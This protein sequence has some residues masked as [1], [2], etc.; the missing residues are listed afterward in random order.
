MNL[1]ILTKNQMWKQKLVHHFLSFLPSRE[2]IENDM[3]KELSRRLKGGSHKETLTN[4]LEWQERNIH[5]WDEREYMFIFLGI[6]LSLSL[7]LS[8]LSIQ[9]F[10]GHFMPIMTIISAYAFYL[11]LSNLGT[12]IIFTLLLAIEAIFLLSFLISHAHIMNIKFNLIIGPLSFIMDIPVIIIIGS[13]TFLFGCVI[14][15]SLYT[16]FKYRYLKAH[17]PKFKL[18]DTFRSSL[19][20]QKILQYNLAICRDYAKLSATLL[21]NYFPENK[22]HFV[23]IPWHVAAAVKIKNR[24]YVLDQKLPVL[25]LERWLNIWSEKTSKEI[26]T[27]IF[28][29]L[30]RVFKGGEV[31]IS[32]I[33]FDKKVSLK[34]VCR[35]K[36]ESATIPDVDTK[37]L[38]SE[39]QRI[40]KVRSS[41]NKNENNKT[42]T[43]KKPVRLF[44]LK[45]E[46]DE[47]VKYSLV[48]A[49]R[50]KVETDFCGCLDKI[51]KVEVMQKEKNLVLK[52]YYKSE[53][54]N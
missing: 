16:W 23:S 50:N 42:E 14:S 9:P 45:Y 6:L 10:L 17:H 33:V 52:I 21:L 13:L 35:K 28:S 49:L 51:S 40:L 54:L 53:C 36:L 39:L 8:V 1:G 43:I 32:K 38:T 48:R 2:D 37:Y 41:E 7:F 12:M 19:S 46:D 25:T 4:I 20:I 26:H 29:W 15:L 44:A 22:V 30:L 31:K 47:I 34:E 27:K 11:M 5:Y 24:L 3:I 18:S